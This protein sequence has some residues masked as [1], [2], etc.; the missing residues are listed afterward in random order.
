MCSYQDLCQDLDRTFEISAIISLC[1]NQSVRP[2]SLQIDNR[3][4]IRNTSRRFYEPYHRYVDGLYDIAVLVCYR[5]CWYCIDID[6]DIRNI[7]GSSGTKKAFQEVHGSIQLSLLYL[8][9]LWKHQS[10]VI[11]MV[12]T[13]HLENDIT[14]TRC[15]NQ[16]Y[17]S[18]SESVVWHQHQKPS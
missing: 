2:P 8:F 10:S 12:S 18:W 9:M 5:T 11:I 4:E 7:N 15:S 17:A 16:V 6:I 3:T 1:D 14:K 13:I